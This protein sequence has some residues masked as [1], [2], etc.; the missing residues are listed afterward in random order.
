MK[1]YTRKFELSTH[2]N[3]H[4]RDKMKHYFEAYH[5][6]ITKYNIEE[7]VFVKK[8]SLLAG[9]RL[10]PLNWESVVEVTFAENDKV[11]IHFT[12]VTNGY[13]TPVAFAALYESYLLNLERY[14]NEN[15][16]FVAKNAISIKK[17][18]VDALKY[19]GILLAGLLIGAAFGIVVAQATEIKLFGY[20]GIFLGVIF[21]ERILNNYLEKTYGAGVSFKVL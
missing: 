1:D 18:K 6:K 2:G 12:A 13:I 10:N 19:H 20:I 8:W 3:Q 17:A 15:I 7:L 21:I 11:H 5:F 4:V 16:E 9:W 14:L